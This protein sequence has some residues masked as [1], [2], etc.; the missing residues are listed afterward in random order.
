MRDNALASALLKR[1]H[2]VV[3]M[4]I[5]TPTTTDETNVSTPHVFFGGVSV[6]LEQ[7]VPF[8]RHT[9][10]FLDRLWDSNAVLKLASKRQIKVDP[11]A[12]GEMTVSM[13]KGTAGHQRKEVEKMQRWLRH[14][15]RFDAVSLPFAL[16]IGLAKPLRETLR[17]PIACTLQ[18]ED[19][20]LDQLPEPWRT[21]SLDL[22]RRA[23]PDV[24][25]FI[26]VS[27][28]YVELHVGL[29]RHSARQDQGRAARHQYGRPSAEGD[30]NGAAVHRRILRS[31]RAGERPA[32]AGGRV[33]AAAR[34][35]PAC[36]RPGCSPA[37]TC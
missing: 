14:E 2:D 26:S 35:S 37:G 1:G 10:A 21:Q 6:F 7:H 25:V 9:P 27:E 33:P 23:V 30:A 34:Q 19:L 22:I 3:L 8:F 36:R 32:R 11:A 15:P 20:F 16:L 31:H 28:S 13:L 17:A 12:L 24:D 4:P 5:Y 29:P 18:G